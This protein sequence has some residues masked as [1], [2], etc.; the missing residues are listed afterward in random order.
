M[1]ARTSANTSIEPQVLSII[2]TSQVSN[3]YRVRSQRKQ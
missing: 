1:L 2:I 3:T